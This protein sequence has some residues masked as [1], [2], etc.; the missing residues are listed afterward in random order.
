MVKL[1]TDAACYKWPILA[2]WSIQHLEMSHSNA[3]V[4]YVTSACRLPTIFLCLTWMQSV[5]TTQMYEAVPAEYQ[6]L[7]ENIAGIRP[8]ILEGIQLNVISQTMKIK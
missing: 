8:Q 1:P 6:V 2:V 7:V 5:M 4:M 3:S